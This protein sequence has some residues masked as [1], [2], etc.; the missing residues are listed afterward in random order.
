MVRVAFVLLFGINKATQKEKR[1]KR[2]LLR[3]LDREP[4]GFGVSSDLGLRVQGLQG[5]VAYRVQGSGLRVLGH[6]S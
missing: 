6:C 5:A 1:G 2:V 3:N 4:T